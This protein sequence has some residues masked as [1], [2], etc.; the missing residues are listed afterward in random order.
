MLATFVITLREGLEAAL[1]VAIIASF[2]KKNQCSLLPL[3]IG[4]IGAVL[5]SFLVGVTLNLTEH[6]LP[7]QAQETME[8]AIALLAIGFISSMLIWMQRQGKQ[9]KQQLQLQASQQLHQKGPLTLGIMAFLAVLREGVETSVFLM[10]TF[11]ADQS[12]LG[13]ALGAIFGLITAIILGLFIYHGSLRVNLRRLFSLSSFLLILVAAGLVISALR[14]AHEAGWLN[15]GQQLSVDLSG[16]LPA[17]RVHTAILSGLLGIP[18]DPRDI[19]VVGWCLYLTL[20]MLRLFWPTRLCLSAR[21]QRNSYHITG[22]ILVCSALV[23]VYLGHKHQPQAYA[24]VTI[25]STDDGLPL[26]GHLSLAN[27]NTQPLKLSLQFADKPMIP[28]FWDGAPR[29]QSQP[30]QQSYQWQYPYGHHSMILSLEQL[31]T[32]FGGRLPAGIDPTRHK[33]PFHAKLTQLC[34]FKMDTDYQQII[35]AK[36]NYT[37]LLTLTGGGLTSRTLRLP[38]TSPPKHCHWQTVLNDRQQDQRITALQ[39]QLM[40]THWQT[41]YFP[42]LCLLLACL[43]WISLW[44]QSARLP[45]SH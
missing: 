41:Y 32:R 8:T 12:S 6:A 15:V 4:V 34:L 38:V 19:E 23:S 25:E 7:Q 14:S 27:L 43:L 17:G 26:Q 11:S 3:W 45:Y 20:M 13:A 31:L 40:R 9:I 24:P 30:H 37:E 29:L 44:R 5:L 22:V 33:G 39:H 21:S 35:S 16:L 2:L 42:G 28:L 36:A 10:A 1:I 18:R